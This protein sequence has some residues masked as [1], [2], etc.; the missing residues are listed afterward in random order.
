MFSLLIGHF[1]FNSSRKIKEKGGIMNNWGKRLSLSSSIFW[2]F[3]YSLG[4]LF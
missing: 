4:N 1:F 3:S 2:L